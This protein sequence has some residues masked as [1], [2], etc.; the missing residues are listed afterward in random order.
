MKHYAIDFDQLKDL[1]KARVVVDQ[2]PLLI[3]H[4][5]DGIYAINDRCPHLGASLVKGTIEDHTVTCKSH[6]A[7]ID[8]KTGEI[9]DR[10]HIA[11]IKMPTKQAKT[12][13]CKV[14]NGKVYVEV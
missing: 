12:Y 5:E 8:L 4:L 7:K 3:V 10:A 13:A 6:K 14:E 9:I 2:K 1:G 11:F